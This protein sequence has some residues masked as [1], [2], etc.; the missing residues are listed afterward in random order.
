MADD[1]GPVTLMSSDG[2]KFEIA[3]RWL[4]EYLAPPTTSF[5]VEW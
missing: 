3:K 5:L 1:D 2:E 4:C